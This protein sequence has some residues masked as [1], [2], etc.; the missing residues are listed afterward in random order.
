[1]K[2]VRFHEDVIWRKSGAIIPLRKRYENYFRYLIHVL[3]SIC[4]HRGGV[5]G[6]VTRKGC[7]D[8][9]RQGLV[10]SKTGIGNE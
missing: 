4:T 9:I 5:E 1:M 7:W 8:H 2:P 6:T 3:V 10:M